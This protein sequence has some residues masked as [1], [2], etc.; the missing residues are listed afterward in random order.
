MALSECLCTK[1]TGILYDYAKKQSY[2]FRFFC[3]LSKDYILP[4]TV[5]AIKS[6]AFILAGQIPGN[7]LI[8]SN[9]VNTP[10]GSF[11]SKS[12]HA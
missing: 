11:T 9:R 12:L 7:I 3:I 1:D 8:S 4:L 6:A 10:R 2:K 5:L